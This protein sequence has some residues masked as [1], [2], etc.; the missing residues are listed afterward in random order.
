[1]QKYSMLNTF[2]D[3]SKLAWRVRPVKRPQPVKSFKIDL[4]F[5][6]CG[7][8]HAGQECSLFLQGE[9]HDAR[10]LKLLSDPLALVQ[11][12]NEHELDADVLA[13]GHLM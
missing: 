8:D 5:L 6:P 2:F 9:V 11:V 10:L 13:I 4:L 1:M 3:E 7:S 12:V